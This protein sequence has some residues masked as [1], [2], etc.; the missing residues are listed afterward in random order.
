MTYRGFVEGQ[1]NFLFPGLVSML[2]LA[3]FIVV[4]L[5]VVKLWK[6]HRDWKKGNGGKKRI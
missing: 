6:A 1:A 4:L 5:F 2:L 3:L